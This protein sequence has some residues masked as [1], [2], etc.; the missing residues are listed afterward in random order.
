MENTSYPNPYMQSQPI[1]GYYQTPRQT[2]QQ[3]GNPYP[4]QQMQQQIVPGPI[5]RIVDYVQGELAATIYP[6]LN[7]QEAM[8]IDIDIPNRVYKKSRSADGKLSPLQKFDLVLFEDKPA[9][10]V[11]MKQY[12]KMEDVLDIISEAVQNEVEKKFSQI[13]FNKTSQKKGSEE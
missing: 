11:D 10:Q 4:P 12:V 2:Y 8:L 7:G 5:P 6:V 1:P 13:S 9:E 3:A